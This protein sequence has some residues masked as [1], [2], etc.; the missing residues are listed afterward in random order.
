MLVSKELVQ[1][2]AHNSIVVGVKAQAH[3]LKLHLGIYD[4]FC[5]F[6][7]LHEVFH[8][9]HVLHCDEVD[10]FW[11]DSHLDLVFESHEHKIKQN[12]HSLIV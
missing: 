1:L 4:E 11:L 9:S 7:P 5:G 8:Y 10:F 2:L 6:L 12:F 3:L